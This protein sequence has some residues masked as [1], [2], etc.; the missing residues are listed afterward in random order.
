M[1]Q[2]GMHEERLSSPSEPR[3]TSGTGGVGKAIAIGLATL[4]VRVGITG[5]E[6]AA[7]DIRG[8][9]GT[10]SPTTPK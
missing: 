10:C 4:G 7:A 8:A 1:S 3:T 2:K 9:S 5:P 6:Q